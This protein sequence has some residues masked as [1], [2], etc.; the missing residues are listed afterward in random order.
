VRKYI[1][2]TREK[3]ENMATVIDTIDRVLDNI[4][5]QEENL[6]VVGDQTSISMDIDTYNNKFKR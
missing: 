2:D 1:D 5:T 6:L 3:M 4:S